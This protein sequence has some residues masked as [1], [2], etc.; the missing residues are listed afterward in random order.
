MIK[1]PLKHLIT[2]KEL[3]K[4]EIN[5]LLSLAREMKQNPCLHSSA[6]Q[7]K[8]IALLFDKPSLRTRVSFTAAIAQLGGHLIESHAHL[9]KTEDPKDLIRVLQGYCSA[10]VIRTFEENFIEA[11]LDYAHIPII[12]GLTNNYHPCQALADML[13]LQEY[14]GQLNLLKLAYIGDGNNTLHSLLIITNTLGIPLNYSCPPNHGPSRA[15]LAGLK[16]P[17]LVKSF[18]EPQ[19]AVRGCN[20]VYTDVWTSMGFKLKDE[21]AFEKFQVNELLMKNATDDAVFMHCM[22]M[23]RGKE[24]SRHLPD[25]PCSLIFK[26]SANRLPIQKALLLKIIGIQLEGG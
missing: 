24:V 11:M 18:S 10:V 4:S 8:S 13:T 6:L 9:R 14:F 2:G 15:V 17:A 21:S 5:Q 1:N 22:P 19:D 25:A 20:A 16:T 26:Q 23:E 12:S 7:G 3:S